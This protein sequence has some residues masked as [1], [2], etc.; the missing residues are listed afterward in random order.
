MLE[1]R[2]RGLSGRER[3]VEQVSIWRDDLI[4]LARSNR[5]IFFKH[6]K[7]S[8][9]EIKI[10]V[11]TEASRII[12]RL[13]EGQ[14]WRFF[15]PP[16]LER[17]PSD[18]EQESL[19]EA[20]PIRRQP[21]P[22]E[23]VTT[24]EDWKLL[25]RALR[26]LERR[27]KQE[28]MDKGL[29]ILYL[30]AGML[31]W[32]DPDRDDVVESPLVFI[33]VSIAR[34]NPREP[35][36]MKQMEEDVVVN[37]ALAIKLAE[38]GV[39]LPELEG[40][41]DLDLEAFL[42]EVESAIAV[43]ERWSVQRR[44]V[45]GA[46]SFHKEVMYRD[47]LNQ[48]DEI[49]D[50]AIIDSLVHGAQE[51]SELDFERIPEARLDEE[52]PPE[53]IVAI[54]DADAT[55][56]QCIAAAE[57]GN[58][59]VM[60]GP[61]GTGK[62]QTIANIIA[63]LLHKAR[64]VLFVSEKAAA[65]DVVKK[66]LAKAGLGH[67][68]LEL[69]SHKVTRKQVSTELGNALASQPAKREEL[70]RQAVSRLKTRRQ[71]L[72]G[73][74]GAMNEIREPLGLSLHGAIGR[75]AQLQDLPQ[76]PL[77]AGVDLALSAELLGRILAAAGSLARSW[78]PVEQGD[79]FLWRDLDEERLDMSTTQRLATE[80]NS[81]LK[82]LDAL[83]RISSDTA[84]GLR[85]PSV[86]RFED[87]DH[88]LLLL[89]QLQRRPDA[90]VEWLTAE[91]LHP[92]RARLAA[93]R[94][95]SHEFDRLGDRARQLL[96][97]DWRAVSPAD[98]D[99][100]AKAQARLSDGPHPLTLP[101]TLTVSE[102][103]ELSEFVTEAPK[104]LR[105]LRADAEAIA[106]VF[107]RDADGITLSRA[108]TFAELGGLAD[109]TERPEAA[110][111]NSARL[112]TVEE[113]AK[114]LQKCA[115][116]VSESRAAAA[117]IYRDEVLELDL[118]SLQKRFS[119]VH[120]GMGK[121][122]GAYRDDKRLLAAATVSGKADRLAINN[123]NAAIEWQAAL[124]AAEA[125]ERKYAD[126]IGEHY[127]ERSNTDFDE[128]NRA[129]ETAREAISLA[130]E[131]QD[132]EALA[133]QLSRGG[134]PN[135]DLPAKSERL[136]HGVAGWEAELE[137][138]LGRLAEE[139]KQLSLA[140]AIDAFTA[141]GQPLRELSKTLETVG[142]VAGSDLQLSEVVEA[143]DSRTKAALIEAE[144][145]MSLRADK[146][147][148]GE[149]FTGLD[150]DWD[151]L[152]S[153]LEWS[154]DVRA[155]AEAKI[156]PAT[157]E[158]LLKVTLEPS[159]LHDAHRNWEEARDHVVAN[160]AEERARGIAA[161]LTT[162]IEEARALLNELLDTIGSIDEWHSF[163]KARKALGDC[164]LA[165]AVQ[166]CELTAV[167]RDDVPGVIERSI[168]EKWVD[169]VLWEESDR[170]GVTRSEELDVQ[171]AE[172]RNLD[173]ELV[174]HS[175]ARVIKACNARRPQTSVGAA[176]LIR[177]E[178]EKKRRHMPV[179]DLLG[180]TRPVAQ[181]LKPCFM[182]SPLT[183]SQFI[184]PDFT[185]DVIIFDEAS[186]VKPGDAI[187]CIYRGRQLIVA[188][189]DKQL[190]PTSFFETG[191]LDDDEE[192]H[193]EQFDDFASVLQQAKAGGLPELSLGW[194]YRS[195]HE[196]LITY[197]N[198]SF[199]S[200]ELIT[201][202]GA[203]HDA[204][205]LGIELFHVQDGVYRRGTSR[206]NPLEAERVVE[207]IL[208]WA[209]DA[210]ESE[211]QTLSVGVVAF[212]D[213]QASAIEAL[214]ERQRRDLPELDDFFTEDRLDGFFIKN[215]ENVQGDERDVMIFSIGYGKDENG[216]FTM[217]FGPLNK[218]G[219]QR[220]LNVA[221]TR[222]RRRVEVVSSVT[223]ADFPAHIE[224]EGPRHLRRYLDFAERGPN[225]L[226]IESDDGDRDT[227]SPFEEEVLRSVRSWGFDV[228]PQV[229]SAG[230]R[231]DLGV[232]DP[233]NPGR[234]ALG[235]ECDGAAYHSSKVARDRDRLRQEVLEGLGWQ[236]HRIWGTSWYRDRDRERQRLRTAIEQA[237]AGSSTKTVPLRHEPSVSPTQGLEEVEEVL[238][239][240]ALDQLPPW[241]QPYDMVLP[242][243][244]SQR[245]LPEIHRP[246]AQ[247][248]LKAMVAQVVKGEGPVSQEVVLRRVR[249]AWGVGR[250]GHR[251]RSAFDKAVARLISAGEIKRADRSFLD[252]PSRRD[253]AV[254]PPGD[255]PD[256]QRSIDEVPPI[257]LQEA[258]HQLV[259]DAL[260]VDRDELSREV[261]RLFGW[262]RRGSDISATLDDAIDDL[263]EADVL[264]EEAGKLTVV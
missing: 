66:R 100:V 9:L 149:Q 50:H 27:A 8:T 58:S 87:L 2:L 61:P 89:A 253:I 223:S 81:A 125:A 232:R 30:T 244:S 102:M 184:P 38:F 124:R 198:Q 64:S 127:Y 185:F 25:S 108:T 19:L 156:A 203:V 190:P 34:P 197:S 230:Y 68:V 99:R 40:T 192:Y 117:H 95:R 140:E 71:E 120:A 63:E 107:R 158:R 263:I 91:S 151:M 233:R 186:Q 104:K 49:A 121:L 161:D 166:F 207:R 109:R 78:S 26:N 248:E 94:E 53:E 101:V 196:D 195:Q 118:E 67:Y 116:A 239:P 211:G 150:S 179:R 143:F 12:Q 225:A 4:N 236:I 259:K 16:D 193:E 213:A 76:A 6:T 154:D 15:H 52:A 214:L 187:N 93:L 264:Q 205:D 218:D 188:G 39:E 173:R 29:W 255:N 191:A 145:D 252:T 119:S 256:A 260:S 3:T 217:N 18:D 228:Q 257:E 23:L 199:Y 141:W 65:L 103:G 261:A 249:Q 245:A 169:L 57:R 44:I 7:V 222:A 242:Q 135:P 86:A 243:A 175:P 136:K 227:E 212:S 110:W 189:D 84:E 113:G 181:A 258:V 147:M 183:V 231:I 163:E 165:D 33:P 250:A 13:S 142:A 47:L 176:G 167:Q 206:D 22:D 1:E 17:E 5:S 202:P 82:T 234:F 126:L 164:G 28:F 224:R 153:A 35:F 96:G 246:E 247:V 133:Q 129:L 139:S 130:S 194:H 162:T 37:P 209:R 200:G 73:R 132:A 77:P 168:L 112:A 62:S 229:G 137:Q 105:A 41:E 45:I 21:E 59:F 114:E 237:I 170:L 148:L 204:S 31:R 32:V 235:V 106:A 48:V 134:N 115:L 75:V 111:L 182:M 216:K 43:R 24:K 157:A 178:A 74:A 88:L 131:G 123:I 70:G 159:D 254:R 98:A 60:D 241:A 208:H 11:P 122:K 97:S 219:G 262:N 138:N 160:F 251:V 240:V 210:T 36:R 221:I 146:D 79:D 14:S 174:E 51:G 54:L 10:L 83:A 238:E 180:Q 177:R 201:F 46:F 171:L 85:L 226:A 215:L 42:N 144:F 90:P 128:L 72:S 92:A 152:K 80:I 56:R 55:Q 172:F 69:H 220:R 20:A 155:L